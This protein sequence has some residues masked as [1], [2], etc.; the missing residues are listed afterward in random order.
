[1]KK[2][3][4]TFIFIL[5]SSFLFSADYHESVFKK[6]QWGNTFLHRL[7]SNNP[8]PSVKD[9]AIFLKKG[10]NINAQND[11]KNTPLHLALINENLKIAEYLVKKGARLDIVNDG[12]TTVFEEAVYRC[13]LPYYSFPRSKLSKREKEYLYVISLMLDRSARV[14]RKTNNLIKNCLFSKNPEIINLLLSKRKKYFNLHER[15]LAGVAVGRID[16]VKSALNHGA[17]IN[18][19]LIDFTPLMIAV[20]EGHQEIAKYL[21][22]KGAKPDTY[23]V[24]CP[25]PYSYSTLDYAIEFK[26]NKLLEMLLDKGAKVSYVYHYTS[27]CSGRKSRQQV[28]HLLSAI[29]YNN[30][31]AFDFM[32]KRGGKVNFPFI[33]TYGPIKL[34]P[35]ALKEGR[36]KFVTRLIKEGAKLTFTEQLKYRYLLIKKK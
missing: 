5:I 16:L 18:T 4:F 34:V 15:L 24:Y 23:V 8:E 13:G 32:L 36:V 9:I 35:R 19:E 2:I 31:E 21:L 12:D 17:D 28:N 7:A 33:G 22:E 26:E 25:A 3:L 11:E 14:K 10:F 29:S 20:R 6:D 27:R 30:Y 1:M